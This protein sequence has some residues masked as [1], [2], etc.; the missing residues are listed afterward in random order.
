[1]TIPWDASAR[2]PTLTDKALIDLVNG[3]CVSR[4]TLAYRRRRKGLGRVL[5]HLTGTHRSLNL[6]LAGNL[7]EGQAALLT[8]TEE[9][10]APA[11]GTVHALTT[12]VGRL[13]E[14]T[15]AVRRN[16]ER[17]DSH[18]QQID[19]LARQ[20]GELAASTQRVLVDHEARLKGLEVRAAVDNRITAWEGGETY[21]RLPILLQLLLLCWEVWASLDS[22][23]RTGPDGN[24]TRDLLVN[25]LH[26]ELKHGFLPDPVS[27]PRLLEATMQTVQEEDTE[28][29]GWM[30][31]VD[32]E[33]VPLTAQSSVERSLALTGD[34]IRAGQQLDLSAE[35]GLIAFAV[36][37]PQCHRL[38][39]VMSRRAL[40]ELIVDGV[41]DARSATDLLVLDAA[42]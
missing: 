32:A 13:G 6:L 39:R 31:S 29:V 18:D 3:L 26:R 10:A 21:T 42:S 8:L 17:L 25:R 12:V 9:L 24:K 22:V 23:H 2:I 41:R 37:E 15:R 27:I 11:T 16:Q 19:D 40:V 33:S 30:L 1:M 4:E 7:V 34:L 38:E 5:D 28:L 20:L 14:V 35:P 36:L